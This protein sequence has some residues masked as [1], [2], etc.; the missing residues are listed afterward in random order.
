[1]KLYLRYLHP[2]IALAA[3]TICV[4]GA[5]PWV[6]EGDDSLPALGNYFLGMGL[7]CFSAFLIL[8]SVA[9]HLLERDDGQS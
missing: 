2:L 5:V 3:L 4:C 1:M 9:R 7:F 6:F 8:G